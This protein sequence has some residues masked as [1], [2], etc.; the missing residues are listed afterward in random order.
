MNSFLTDG[1]L[2]NALRLLDAAYFSFDR[3]VPFLSNEKT[4]L[5]AL[6]RGE[7]VADVTAIDAECAAGRTLFMRPE[8]SFKQNNQTIL[9]IKIKLSLKNIIMK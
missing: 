9:K 6:A 5:C 4:R 1:I 8:N 2:K 3:K 7:I